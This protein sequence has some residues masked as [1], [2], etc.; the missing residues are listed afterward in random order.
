MTGAA[1]L[2]DAEVALATAVAVARRDTP[3]HQLAL[4]EHHVAGILR[5][6]PSPA[7]TAPDAAPGAAIDADAEL[8]AFVDAFVSDVS[9]LDGAVRGPVL[10]RHGAASLGLVQAV[11]LI[12]LGTRRDL[13]RAGLGLAPTIPDVAAPAP[14]ADLELW[15][16]LEAYWRT[17]ARLDSLD[18]LTTELVRLR[19]A[20][21]H[22]CRLCS[23]RR[24]VSALAQ[25]AADPAGGPVDP[26]EA[27]FDAQPTGLDEAQADAVALVDAVIWE[28]SA[29][30]PDLALRLRDAYLDEQL[31]EILHDV[32]RNAANKIAV[33]FGA[34][35]AN[36]TDGVELFDLD[37]DG[38]VVVRPPAG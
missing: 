31:E 19:G 38:E 2:T 36:V 34:D 6:G 25:V 35:A 14:P 7:P 28:P 17:V 21:A 4:I 18:P 16:A 20:A 10:T 30:D 11:Y 1:T 27:V 37:D 15:P 26:L 3:P 24:N 9:R 13:V 5:S 32:V 33:A 8:G 12:D 29:L 22:N 23:S